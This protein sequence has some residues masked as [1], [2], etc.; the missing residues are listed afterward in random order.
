MSTLTWDDLVK[1]GDKLNELKNPSFN[2]SIIINDKSFP[3][4]RFK[5]LSSKSKVGKRKVKVR[6]IEGF[7][8]LIPDCQTLFT[9]NGIIMNSV[10]KNLLDKEIKRQERIRTPDFGISYVFN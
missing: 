9:N 3:N 2:G 8:K 6:Y 10:T 1:V 4:Y 5:C 7:T